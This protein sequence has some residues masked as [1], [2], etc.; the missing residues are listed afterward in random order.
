MATYL[1]QDV[2]LSERPLWGVGGGGRGG[3]GCKVSAVLKWLAIKCSEAIQNRQRPF[4]LLTYLY[5]TCELT[6]NLIKSSLVSYSLWILAELSAQCVADMI[7]L[8]G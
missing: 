7:I 3:W 5:S 1:F 8:A 2:S 6:V 4:P